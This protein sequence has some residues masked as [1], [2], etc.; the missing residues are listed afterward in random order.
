M[1]FTMQEYKTELT[2]DWIN[3]YL[4]SSGFC[5]AG[6]ANIS[7]FHGPRCT[8]TYEKEE[9]KIYVH[10]TDQIP[11]YIVEMKEKNN[12]VIEILK[13]SECDDS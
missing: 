6:N 1:G 5:I 11:K 4:Y 13:L 2:F 3:K 7:H 9:E 12:G 8:I 10:I